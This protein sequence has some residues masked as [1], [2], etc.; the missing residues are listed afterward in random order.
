MHQ[1][2]LAFLQSMSP[3]TRRRRPSLRAHLPWQAVLLQTPTPGTGP[4]A[5]IWDIS[6]RSTVPVSWPVSPPKKVPAIRSQISFLTEAKLDSKLLSK[7]LY[8]FS[9]VILKNVL[10]HLSS[11][12]HSTFYVGWLTTITKTDFFKCW[13]HGK[14]LK[15]VYFPSTI[16]PENNKSTFT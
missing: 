13:L 14:N 8:I 5:P 3:S 4:W 12:E 7:H 6:L 9:Y 10:K 16:F 11:S 15:A 1:T 2:A